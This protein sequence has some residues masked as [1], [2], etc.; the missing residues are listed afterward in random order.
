MKKKR[1]LIIFLMFAQQC[2]VL[3]LN[4]Q[5]TPFSIPPKW[6]FGHRAGMDFTGGAPVALGGNV[7]DAS[8]YSNQEDY[9]TECLPSGNVLYYCNSC[10]LANGANANIAGM[11]PP[12]GGGN[13]STQG[14]ISIPDPSAPTTKFYLI[15]TDVDPSGGSDCA[16]A[17]ANRG[18]WVY[19]VNSA[20]MV[21]GAPTQLI[22]GGQV[23]E[24]ITTSSDNA[25]GYWII[26]H[27]GLN[28]AINTTYYAWHVTSAGINTTAVVSTGTIQAASWRVQG[29]LKINKCNTQ[30]A[31]V[32]RGGW[33]VYNWNATTGALGTVINS[34]TVP[35]GFAYGCEFSPDGKVLYISDLEA[36]LYQVIISSGTY[37]TVSAAS[38]GNGNVGGAAGFGNMMIGPDNKIYVSLI[39]LATSTVNK[40][41]GIINSPNTQTVAGC[42]F[43]QGP[44]S[45]PLA[46]GTNYPSSFTGLVN[47][48]WHNPNLPIT[49]S[50]VPTCMGFS[51]TYNQYY[52]VAVPVLANSEEWDFGDGGGWLTGLG[53]T[54]THTYSSNN[55]YTVKLRL[56]DQ[57]CQTFYTNQQ[58]VSVSCVLPIELL[59]FK[60]KAENGGATLVWQTATEL[61]NDYFDLQRSTDGVNFESI[62]TIKGAGNST[63]LLSYSYFDP[64]PSGRQ[65]YYKLVQ[66][67]FD[68]ATSGSNI[69][70]VKLDKTFAASVS[71]MPNPFSETFVL[72]KFYN[73]KATV[74]IYD[75]LGRV[76][77]QRSS[78]E[79]ETVLQLGTS[80]VK[81]SYI[82]EYI[83]T[84]TSYTMKV[85]KQ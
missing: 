82:I 54:P 37:N 12:K 3:E 18:V 9:T 52:G 27:G 8:S 7:W 79:S 16:N 50:T 73:E 21:I 74:L 17:V 70:T 15:T 32:T 56:K 64:S 81:G 58:S 75:I 76:V 48:G 11:A 78:P 30:I 77:D 43:V 22:A 66:H 13:S 60:G 46:V 20:G 51:Y 26:S 34:G 35:T 23:G 57:D 39:W 40:Y 4:A 62:A 10:N 84:E 42:N 63:Q 29:G 38:V 5:T 80:L 83:T 55:T 85:E 65:V 25:G 41:V 72:T 1:L 33:E 61:N 71:V 49:S 53:S 19:P 45:F 14:S 6:Y 31:F 47:L 69:V 67:D 28:D 59:S 44:G 2:C 36:G 68:G 24:T